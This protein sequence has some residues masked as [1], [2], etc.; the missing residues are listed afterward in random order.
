MIKK[1]LF[2][3]I[4]IAILGGAYAYYQ[5][6]KPVASIESKKPDIVV[7]ANDL[8]AAYDEDENA[9]NEKYTEKII[10]V[11]GIISDVVKEGTGYKIFIETDNP[12]SGVIC[13]MEEGQDVGSLKAGDEVSVKGRCTGFLSDVILKQ[14]SL[15]K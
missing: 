11:K 4:I 2:A 1:I 13:E 5:Y 15:I 3:I 6:N 10:Q 12:M 9:A 14:S 7:S 8:F